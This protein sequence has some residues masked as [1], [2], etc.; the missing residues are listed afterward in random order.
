MRRR[1]FL[2][3]SAIYHV[4]RDIASPMSCSALPIRAIKVDISSYRI[5]IQDRRFK[6]SNAEM[7]ERTFE[8]QKVD[9]EF[10]LRRVFGKTSFR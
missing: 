10:T 9:L 5:D 1:Y 6:R 2:L 4:S 3:R 7:L 8:R